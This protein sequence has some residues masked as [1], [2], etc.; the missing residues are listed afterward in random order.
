LKIYKILQDLSDA[1]WESEVV[2]RV[3]LRTPDLEEEM[4]DDES[5]VRAHGSVGNAPR[6]DATS[7]R[8]ARQRAPPPTWRRSLDRLQTVQVRTLYLSRDNHT[9]SPLDDCSAGAA[10]TVSAQDASSMAATRH[11]I[12]KCS[13]CAFESRSLSA[14]HTHARQCQPVVV[15]P[16]IVRARLRGSNPRR[17][18]AIGRMRL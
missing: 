7:T 17:I 16:P 3:E 10:T 18:R 9:R 6:T 14:M 5:P 11:R 1:Q 12:Y 4:D 2:E 15:P 13:E 8:S